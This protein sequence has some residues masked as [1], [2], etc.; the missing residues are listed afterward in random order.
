M[1]GLGF[2]QSEIVKELSVKA[3]VSERTIYNDFENRMQWQP[4]HIAEREVYRIVNLY[5]QIYKKAAFKY[6]SS[7]N[8]SIQLGA[9]KVML[10]IVKRQHEVLVLPE[11]VERLKLLEE[12]AA[13]GVF[14][15]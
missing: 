8:E 9:L 14:V 10:E 2:S 7:Q 11:L 5:D 15:K 4:M 6:L 12:K 1:E 3:R 13:K